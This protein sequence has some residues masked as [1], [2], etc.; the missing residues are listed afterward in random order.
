MDWFI[1]TV[2]TVPILVLIY[3]GMGVPLALLALPRQDW[4]DRPLVVMCG[5]GFGAALLTAYLFIIGTW[6]QNSNLTSGDPLNPMQTQVNRLV[7]GHAFM[8]DPNLP[9]NILAITVLLWILAIAKRINTR[10]NAVYIH[11]P[12]A[13]DEKFLIALVVI[14]TALRWVMTAWTAFGWYDELWV[15]GYQS[16][17]YTLLGYIPTDIGYYPQFL[18]LQYAFAQISTGGIND[19]AARAVLPFLQIGSILAAYT[20]GNRLINRRVGI[21]LAGIWALYPHFGFWTRIGDLEIPQAYAF[22]ASS[23]FFLMAWIETDNHLRARYALLAGVWL[24][25]LMWIKPTGGALIWGVMLMVILEAIRTRRWRD[26]APRFMVAFRMAVACLPLGSVWYIRNVL[27]GHSA[28]T[29]P[30]SYWLDEAMRSGSEFGWILL[31]VGVL[32]AFLFIAPLRSRPNRL[33]LVLGVILIALGVLP[34][35]ITPGRMANLEWVAFGLGM[36]IICITLADFAFAHLS[37]NA[38]H[39]VR[40]VGWAYAL[41]FPYFITYFYSYSYHYRLSFPIVPL[42]ILP[43]AIILG[44]WITPEKIKH[45]RFPLRFGYVFAIFVISLHGILIPLYDEGYGWDFWWTMPAK[46]DLSDAS[47]IE[48]VRY[49]E[50]V[51]QQGDTPRILAPGLQRLPFFFPLWDIN[52]TTIPRTFDEAGDADYFIDGIE[53]QALYANTGGFHNPF[54]ASLRRENFLT[55]PPIRLEDWREH[56]DIY[57]IDPQARF[58]PPAPQ[59]DLTIEIFPEGEVRFGEFARLV[60]YGLVNAPVFTGI[61]SNPV[62]FKLVWQVLA[63]TDKDYAIFYH[64]YRESDP[65]TILYT[66]DGVVNKPHGWELNYYSTQFWQQGEYVIDR[67]GFYIPDLPE[68]DDYRV[69]VGFYDLATGERLPMSVFGIVL[70]DGFILDIPF[71]V[72]QDS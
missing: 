40:L 14:A 41:A 30:Q 52:I 37:E 23:A 55:T 49:F 56:F 18:Q 45:W 71:R 2:N 46:D 16:R 38:W 65:E 13:S 8:R 42:L 54:Y 11:R 24:G 64:L 47:L 28:I 57:A 60:S 51:A 44:M 67:R 48:L 63:P 31:T 62:E 27:Y 58:I 59:P 4:G 15:Y 66:A 72:A 50:A 61:G 39:Y 32:I 43:T 10:H 7:G 22:T 35:I 1:S 25:I 6:G 26:F 20:L 33:M 36:V 29:F 68:G 21:V 53:A 70:S 19:H 9:L 69:R 3:I 12:L 34:T 5:I 17:I